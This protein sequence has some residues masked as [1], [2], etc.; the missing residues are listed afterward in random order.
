[1]NHVNNYNEINIKMYY[2]IIKKLMYLL[3]G[4]KP[5]IAFIMR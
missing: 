4:I 5:D 2:H 1:M 3:C